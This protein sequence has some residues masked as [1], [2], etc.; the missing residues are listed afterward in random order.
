MKSRAQWQRWCYC[1]AVITIDPYHSIG[2]GS[3]NRLN[4]ADECR[5]LICVQYSMFVGH[6]G[7]GD[8]QLERSH[9]VN[10]E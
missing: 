5:G 9:N 8:T 6:A 3:S 4:D 1:S 10:I 2:G 7:V